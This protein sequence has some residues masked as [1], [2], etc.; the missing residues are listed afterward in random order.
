M[1]SDTG[2]TPA[3]RC[4]TSLPLAGGR[5]AFFGVCTYQQGPCATIEVD[6]VDGEWL[7][8]PPRTRSS[9]P[10]ICGD[11]NDCACVVNGDTCSSFLKVPASPTPICVGTD[12]DPGDGTKLQRCGN[13]SGI[14]L[15]VAGRPLCL[16]VCTFDNSTASPK[17]C[18]GLNGCNVA[19]WTTDPTTKK[20]TGVGYCLGGCKVDF[21]CA[22]SWCQPETRW[23]VRSLAMFP[24][25]LGE[26][27]ASESDCACLRKGYCADVCRVGEACPAG[28]TC[29]PELPADV[30]TSLPVG[31]MG[32][33][34]KDC[35]TDTDCPAGKCVKHAGIDHGTCTP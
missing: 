28:F 4:P 19:G 18:P 34:L 24:K 33:C 35:T 3:T 25:K 5:C 9:P 6:C 21:G 22:S 14:C 8:R 31:L 17:G 23:C 7:H 26:A 2:P 12:C 10:S 29:D 27:C 32:H 30:F 15:P 1:P 13:N 16:P 11:H 20:A